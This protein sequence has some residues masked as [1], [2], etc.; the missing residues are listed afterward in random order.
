MVYEAKNLGQ[1]DNKIDELVKQAFVEYEN[2]DLTTLATKVEVFLNMRYEG[3]DTHL[4]VP[5]LE[6]QTDVDQEFIQRHKNEFGFTLD[7]KVLVDDVQVLLVAQSDDKQKHDPFDEFTQL[8]TVTKI[9]PSKV[10]KPIY[11]EDQ[12]WLNSSVYQL[13]DLSVGDCIDGPAIIIDNTQTILVEPKSTAVILKNHIFLLVE[14]ETRKELSKTVVDP[15]QL[16]VFGHRFMS[17][18]SKWEEHYNKQQFQQ[19]SKKDWTSRVLY[20]I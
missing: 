13:P 5:K 16:S 15:I 10:I 20:L 18:L 14:G 8:G 11:F 6:N 7:R 2:Q 12:Q 17:I 3:S 1:L 9:A 19:I 4:L